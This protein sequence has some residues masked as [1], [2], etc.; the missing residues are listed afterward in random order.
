MVRINAFALGWHS[1]SKDHNGNSAAA[2]LSKAGFHPESFE[3][4]LEAIRGLA[5]KMKSRG[6]VAF[7]N[8]LAY[9]GNIE[10]QEPSLPGEKVIQMK[11]K[12][13]LLEIMWWILFVALGQKWT[14]PAD[15]SRNGSHT[16]FTSHACGGFD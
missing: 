14:F 8:A 7:K 1:K 9:D 6:Q 15:A 11:R 13:K 4:Y 2:I 16:K 12:N 3:D 5:G 10:F